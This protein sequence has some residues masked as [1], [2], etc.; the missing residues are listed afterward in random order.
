M[1]EKICFIINPIAGGKRENIKQLI[2]EKLDFQKYEYTLYETKGQG[3]ARELAKDALS[4]G[5]KKII[6]SGGDGTV[7]E[8][9]SALIET[10]AVMG[11]IPSGSGN[12]LARHLK[13]PVKLDKA[14]DIINN[15]GV[16]P[17]DYG[18]I[19]EIPFFCTAGLGFDAHIGKVFDEGDQRGF[20]AYTNAVFKE[21]FTYKEKKYKIRVDEKEIKTRAFLLTIANASQFGNNA[22]V[23]PDAKITD[24][25]LDVTIVK[26]FPKPKAIYLGV[27]LFNKSLDRS[28]YVNIYRT[29]KV[30]VIRKK[31]GAVHYD[32]E[33]IEMGK[34]IRFRVVPNGLKVMV[35]QN[36]VF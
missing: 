2:N 32:G 4:K 20:W 13:I 30:A 34:K 25:L 11:I 31:K 6:A 9:G 19:N 26:P 7:N 36:K 35:K 14:M 1:K 3:D 22:Y 12:G 16:T 33:P 23:S 8:V 28:K 17:I 24:G 21:F 29:E 18:L 15:P 27:R 10:D 5:Y